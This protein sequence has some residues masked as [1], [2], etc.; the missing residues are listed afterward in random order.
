VITGDAAMS[1]IAR[2][3]VVLVMG[4]ARGRSPPRSSWAVLNRCGSPSGTDRLTVNCQCRLPIQ[5]REWDTPGPALRRNGCRRNEV[6]GETNRRLKPVR[7]AARCSRR[8]RE[9]SNPSCG[10]ATTHTAAPSSTRDGSMGGETCPSGPD[11]GTL[12]HC[13]SATSAVQR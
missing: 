12:S 2:L 1:P 7:S 5:R 9:L 4:G 13:S 11:H 10:W 3:L 8:W 6:F